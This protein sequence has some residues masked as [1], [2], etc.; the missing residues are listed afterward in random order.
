MADAGLLD[1]I[2]KGAELKHVET[3]DKS[4]PVIE[5][6]EIKKHDRGAF[7]AEVSGDHQLKHAE[8]VDKSVPVI[9]PD[10][11]VGESKRPALLAEIQAKKHD[12]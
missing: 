5:A 4:V 6:V 10:V 2:A 11:H 1:A 3:A 8:T 7:L 9:T 12:E